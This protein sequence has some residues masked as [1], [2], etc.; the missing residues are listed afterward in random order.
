VTVIKLD[1]EPSVREKDENNLKP[2]S[3]LRKTLKSGIAH[4]RELMKNFGNHF[5]RDEEEFS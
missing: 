4:P 1:G 2:K 5:F 3:S